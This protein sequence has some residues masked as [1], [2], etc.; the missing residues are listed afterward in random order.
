MKILLIALADSIHT[1]RWV[2]QIADMGWDVRLF[3]S[4]DHGVV[5]PSLACIPVYHTLGCQ[6]GSFDRKLRW[7]GHRLFRSARRFL[8]MRLLPKLWPRR[9]VR[10]LLGVIAEFQPDIIH[11]LEFQAAGYLAAEVKR[12]KKMGG[13]SWIVTNWGSDIYYFRQFPDHEHKIREVLA[14]CDYYTCECRRDVCLAEGLGLKGMVLP[15]FPNAGGFDLDAV[16]RLR[17]PGP[18]SSRRTI[19]LKGYQHWVGRALVGLVA[20]EQ[21]ADLLCDYVVVIHSAS[22]ETR[23][24][25]VAFQKRTGITVTFLA[26]GTPHESILA[27]YGRARVAI[28]LSLSDGIS[29][30]FLEGLVMG[31][32]PIQSW[33]ACADEWITDGTTGF[34]VPPEDV[35]AVAAAL[36][37]ALTDD[38]LVDQAAVLNAVTARERLDQRKIREM[39]IDYYRTVAKDSGLACD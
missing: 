7:Q 21:C 2:K 36:R 18:V 29:T 24:A 30:S 33:T 9:R 27:M 38:T 39:A 34:L 35:S 16:E 26:K 1:A 13:A 12:E 31:A 37:W 28:G 15:V 11:S 4:I 17:Q 22:P 6:L 5:H 10:Q 14:L 25:A 23:K 32:F 8:G 3:P 20:L 19:V